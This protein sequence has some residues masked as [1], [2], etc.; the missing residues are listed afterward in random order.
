MSA[1]PASEAMRAAEAMSA[2][3]VVRVCAFM[4]RPWRPPVSVEHTPVSAQGTPVSA[5]YPPTSH[6]IDGS[7]GHEDNAEHERQRP[8]EEVLGMSSRPEFED[9]P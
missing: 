7:T 9:R 6:S 5:E 8:R 2:E 3:A 4:F 1:Q